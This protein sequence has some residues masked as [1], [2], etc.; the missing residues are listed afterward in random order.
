MKRSNI[1]IKF[2]AEKA[3][4]STASVSYVLNNI[5]HSRVTEKTK[6]KILSIAK[7]YN[8]TPNILA[9]SL[10]MS[11]TFN[12]GFI[13]TLPLSQFVQD[14]FL[15]SMF[16]GIESEIENKS[17]S[18]LYSIYKVDQGINPSA[19]QLIHGHIADGILLYGTVEESLLNTIIKSGIKFILIDYYINHPSITAILPDNING[20]Y[21][22]IK[23]LINKKLKKIFCINGKFNHPSYKER[24]NGYKKAMKEHRLSPVIYNTDSTINGTYALIESL[25]HN[26]NLPEAFFATGDS[27]AV[28]ILRCLLDH[29][30]KVPQQIKVIGF[31]NALWTQNERI[32]LTTVNIPN[33]EMGQQAVQ[34]L[35]GLIENQQKPKIFRVPTKLVIKES[36]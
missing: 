31:D 24:P 6:K 12:I 7:K 5:P 11:R 17:Y 18:L 34:I 23:Y 28:G 26:K 16:A 2:I 9:R 25:I 35:L 15:N 3:R 19:N 10:A 22:A 21:K 30:I 1:T 36:A 27:M 29:K 14:S 8:Y 13:N 32:K 20:A 33:I 4:V